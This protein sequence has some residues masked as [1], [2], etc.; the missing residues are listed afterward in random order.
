MKKEYHS[1]EAILYAQ[2]TDIL[3]SSSDPI[4][5]EEELFE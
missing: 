2:G 5:T 3:T 4:E 1:P